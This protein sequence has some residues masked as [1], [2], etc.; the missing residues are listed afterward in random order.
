MPR[1]LA[2]ALLTRGGVWNLYGPTEST[3]WSTVHKVDSAEGPVPIGRPIANTRI[4]I[5]DSHLQ[6]VPIGVHADLYIGGDGLARSYWHNPELTAEG[7]IPD[8]FSDNI[9]ARLYRTGDQARY[10]PDGSVEFLG[11]TD[12]QV[13]IRGHRIELGEIESA[14]MQHPAVNDAVV[15]S[16]DEFAHE[17]ENPKSKIENPKSIVAYVVS[18]DK[19]EPAVRDLRQFLQNKLPDYTIP[20]SFVFLDALPL[21]SNG[22]LD[23]SALPRPDGERPLLSHGFV[24][25][26]TEIEELAAQFWSE[27]LKRDK[28]GVYDNFFD[29]GG[30]SLHATRVIAN[31]QEVFNKP[32]PL[33]VLFDAPTIAELA[34]ELEEIARHGHAPE[35]PPIVS[36]PRDGPLPLS[37]NQEHLWHLD[38]LI[39]GTRFFNMPYAYRLTGQLN[40]EALEKALSEIIRRHEALRTVFDEL[41]GRPVQIIK[42]G[43]D[44]QLQTVDFRGRSPK[45]ASLAAAEHIIEERSAPFDLLTGPLR[46]VKL[47]RLTE[48]DALLLITMHHIISDHWS[49]QVFRQELIA[50][51]RAEAQGCQSSLPRPPIQCVD[52]ALWERHLLETGQFTD[53]ARHWGT[54]LFKD[55]SGNELCVTSERD[56]NF[57]RQ[58]RQQIVDIN[59]SLLDKVRRFAAQQNCTL[60]VVVLGAIFVTTYLIFGELEI[61]CGTLMSNRRKRESHGAIGHFLNTVIV[62]A[63]LS[64]HDTF[65]RMLKKVRAATL[66]AHA[67]QEI[68]FEQ[69]R[70]HTRSKT[71]RA[72][73]IHVL[74]N[75]Q[76]RTFSASNLAGLTFAPY[77]L[78]ITAVESNLLP[79]AY[80]LIFDI[81]EMSTSVIGTVNVVYDLCKESGAQNANATLREVLNLVVSEPS[82][83]L[84]DLITRV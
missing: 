28:V 79:A 6:P 39:P 12:N 56:N 64:P 7:F 74:L 71:G 49:M 51:Y 81:K 65:E 46:R 52:Y 55:D 35:L 37:L 2:E 40:V 31:L 58:F 45:D 68:P 50:I 47:L 3:I 26:R 22:K 48:T 57:V 41:D 25:P 36:A 75:Y 78:P 43:S 14:L 84:R 16:F 4:Y 9:A 77:P 34:V 54:H 76:T 69:L 30:H 8:P 73:S 44:F 13:K 63:C 61:L 72:S 62:R 5:L 66:A 83:S 59:A 18:H 32:V 24:E 19:P 10:R 67:N 15:I 60:F 33:R 53:Q 11:R 20:S 80:D 23:R 17:C 38:R 29:L 27:V 42:D 70:R 21:T 1:D 82:T